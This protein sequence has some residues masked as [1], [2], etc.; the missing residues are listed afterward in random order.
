MMMDKST[1]PS[2]C[3]KGSVG[4]FYEYSVY[5]V[6]GWTATAPVQLVRFGL[7]VKTEKGYFSHSVG[8]S[9]QQADVFRV[10]ESELRDKQA[11]SDLC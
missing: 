11:V 6:C 4:V 1:R 5:R 7:S 9:E 3:F 10:K 8:V 2:V